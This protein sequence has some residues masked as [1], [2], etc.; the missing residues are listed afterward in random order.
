MGGKTGTSF[1]PTIAKQA[2][3]AGVCFL[4]VAL[5]TPFNFEGETHI[6]HALDG[7]SQ[8]KSLNLDLL[9]ILDNEKL[10]YQY[11]NI[12]V[13]NAFDYADKAVLRAVEESMGTGR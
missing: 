1:T 10:L 7:I 9:L 11:G 2:K 5:T 4:A 3:S 8:L 13:Y 6:G 12:S